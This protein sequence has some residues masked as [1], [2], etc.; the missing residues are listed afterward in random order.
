MRYFHKTQQKFFCPTI[1]VDK[2]VTLVD[3]EVLDKAG[4]DG[5]LPVINCV[6]KGFYKVLGNGVWKKPAIVKAKFFSKLAEK[7]ILAAGGI[8]IPI[9]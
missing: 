4:V 9:A 8:C 3:K 6:Q 2:L 5:V 1:N 7:K